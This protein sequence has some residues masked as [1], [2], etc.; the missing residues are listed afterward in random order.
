LISIASETV[1]D[2]IPRV[3]FEGESGRVSYKTICSDSSE[4]KLERSTVKGIDNGRDV[5]FDGF[6][7]DVSINKFGNCDNVI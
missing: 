1:G 5:E 7:L 6:G 2:K 3:N 4:L